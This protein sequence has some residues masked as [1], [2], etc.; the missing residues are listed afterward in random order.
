MLSVLPKE[1][2]KV[3]LMRL[4]KFV[5]KL[6]IIKEHEFGFRKQHNTVL[7]VARI[8]SDIAYEYNM[9]NVTVMALRI[10]SG[11][12]LPFCRFLIPRLI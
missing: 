11:E 10:R 3:I 1:M 8:V 7:Q 2:D 9:G 4:N 12:L 5:N 6:N